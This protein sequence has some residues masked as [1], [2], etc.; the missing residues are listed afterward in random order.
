MLHVRGGDIEA[1]VLNLRRVVE[2]AEQPV[3]VDIQLEDTLD[4]IRGLL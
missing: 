2:V 1:L 3:D 4:H